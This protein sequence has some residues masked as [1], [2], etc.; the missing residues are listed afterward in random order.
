MN[1]SAR[2]IG[3]FGGTFDPVHNGHLA[4]AKSFLESDLIEELWIF[5]SPYPPHKESESITADYSQRLKMLQAAFKPVKKTTISD[6]E[7]RLPKPSYTVQTI[8]Y[9]KKKHPDFNFFLCVGKDSFNTFTTWYR[10][11][12]ILGSVRLLVADRPV[13]RPKNLPRKLYERAQFINHEAIAVSSTAIRK[14]LQD[15]KPIDDLVPESVTKIIEE[16]NLYQNK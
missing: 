7:L 14:R 11:E 13:N 8:K 3:I 5:L 2:A 15:G 1:S 12:E 16:E 6:L 4:I 9:L 10:W